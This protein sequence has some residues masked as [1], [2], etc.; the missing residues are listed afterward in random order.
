M[1][2]A[3]ELP[4]LQRCQYCGENW[5][6]FHACNNSFTG[7]PVNI[8]QPYVIPEESPNTEKDDEVRYWKEMYFRCLTERLEL[9][10]R[11]V[12]IQRIARGDKKT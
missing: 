10:N 8:V 12:E 5:S 4:I 7:H 2:K 6:G 11:L 1:F 9:S 3:D